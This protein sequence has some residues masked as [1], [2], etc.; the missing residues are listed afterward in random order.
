MSRELL[1][2]EAVA[3]RSGLKPKSI[4]DYEQWG[5]IPPRDGTVGR[6]AFWWSDNPEF[7]SWLADRVAWWQTHKEES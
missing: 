6:S 1:D 7:V 3:E 2:V 4:R 5:R